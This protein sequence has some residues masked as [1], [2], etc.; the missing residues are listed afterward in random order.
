M[1]KGV[2][3][4]PDRAF[5]KTL[6]EY[7]NKL[8][9]VFDRMAERFIIRRQRAFGQPW[10]VLLVETDDAQFRQPDGR[11][12]RKLYEADLWKNGGVDA[13]IRRGEQTMWDYEEKLERDTREHFRAVSRDNKIQLKNTYRKATNMGSKAPELRKIEEVRK[14][15]ALTLDQIKAARAAGRD[16]W[17]KAA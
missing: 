14:P 10:G 3:P 9:I 12:M 11:D 4:V 15:G 2:P 17:V 1:Y 6:K 8:D 5:V 7:D 13:R 16:P